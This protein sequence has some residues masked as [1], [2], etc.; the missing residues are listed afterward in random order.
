MELEA[1]IADLSVSAKVHFFLKFLSKNIFNFLRNLILKILMFGLN[2][3]FCE[4]FHE[5]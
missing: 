5:H 2:K 1:K 3:Q 4:L